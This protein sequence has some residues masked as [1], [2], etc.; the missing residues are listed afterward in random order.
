MF[1]GLDVGVVDDNVIIAI[2]TAL[3]VKETHGMQ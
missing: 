1:T 2:S 3:L